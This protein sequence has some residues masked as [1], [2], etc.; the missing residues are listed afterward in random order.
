[1]VRVFPVLALLTIALVAC[2]APPSKSGQAAASSAPVAAASSAP[3]AAPA[4]PPQPAHNWAYKQGEDYA[5]LTGTSPVGEAEQPTMVRY[6]GVQDGVY[7]IIETQQ[8]AV[9]GASCA[10]PCDRVRLRGKGLDQTLA[11]NPSSIV[12]A[13]LMDAMNGQLDVYKVKA[14]SDP[15]TA[16]PQ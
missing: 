11:L 12:Y 10:K 8:G 2:K 3:A 15:K 13:A 4:S 6:L 7:T 9:V 14:S 1:L 5:Y 16:P